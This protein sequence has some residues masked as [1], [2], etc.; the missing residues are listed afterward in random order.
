M[1]HAI[2]INPLVTKNM[3]KGLWRG[4]AGSVGILGAQ[5]RIISKPEFECF[6]NQDR[7]TSVFERS[8]A[9]LRSLQVIIS[10]D[11]IGCLNWAKAQIEP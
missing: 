2:C 8:A 7:F 11:A 9:E 6:I 4:V 1:H 5:F 10:R 3:Q